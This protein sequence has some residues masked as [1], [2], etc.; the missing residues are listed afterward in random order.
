VDNKAELERDRERL[1]EETR[2][3]CDSLN[4]GITREALEKNPKR[5]FPSKEE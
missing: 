1:N 2:K 4:K 5:F 3:G